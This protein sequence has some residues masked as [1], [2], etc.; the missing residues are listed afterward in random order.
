MSAQGWA[1]FATVLYVTGLVALFG[2]RTWRHRRATGSSGFNGFARRD[3]WARAAGLLFAVAVLAGTVALI[4]AAAGT[5]PVL[6]PGWLV[7]PLAVA[8]LLMAAAGIGL[9][10]VAHRQWVPP[11]G[12]ASTLGRRP[13]WLRPG[14]S[15]EPETRSS[16]PWWPRR[17]ALC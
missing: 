14:C 1:A 16:P 5:T 11:G 7:Q 10:W 17:Q 3:G 15:P 9:A 6:T 8:G 4:L 12:S 2:L 13:S